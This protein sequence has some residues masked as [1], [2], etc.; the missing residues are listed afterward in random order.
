M[1]YGVLTSAAKEAAL[2]EPE[3]APKEGEVKADGSFITWFDLNGHEHSTKPREAEEVFDEPA[4][5]N[6]GR[7]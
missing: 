6:A 4:T 2:P 7:R 1:E 3:N 5:S